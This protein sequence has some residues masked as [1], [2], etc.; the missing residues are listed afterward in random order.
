MTNYGSFTDYGY[1]GLYGGERAADIRR[2]KGI[3]DKENPMDY[4]GGE[5]LGG[6]M[7]E[8]LPTPPESIQKLERRKRREL[9][10]GQ[11]NAPQ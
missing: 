7:P 11:E 6:T 9:K 8:D 4:A 3:G 1:L 10:S 5:E 2:R